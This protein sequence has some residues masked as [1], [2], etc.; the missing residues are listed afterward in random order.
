MANE[1]VVQLD[2]P[3]RR[4]LDFTVCLDMKRGADECE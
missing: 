3:R 1:N 4:F 2:A